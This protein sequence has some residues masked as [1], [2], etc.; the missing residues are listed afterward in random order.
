[1]PVPKLREPREMTPIRP[2]RGSVTHATSL[3]TP[4]KTACGRR[5]SGWMISVE[6]VDCLDCKASM[7]GDVR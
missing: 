2:R 7:Y 6:H 4:S 1:M 3:E 5:C